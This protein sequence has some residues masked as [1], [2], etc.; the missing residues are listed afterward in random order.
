MADVLTGRAWVLDTVAGYVSSGPVKIHS[1]QFTFTTAAAA[2]F[3]LS[4]G[5][6]S[7]SLSTTNTILNYNTT[8]ASTA[9]VT[10]LTRVVYF[11]GLS[12]DGLRKQV[13]VQMTPPIIVV[14]E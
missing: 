3:K 7:A 6:E 2:S 9:A 14:T 10:D 13:C 1:V 12:V 11:G 4:F 5:T 8:A